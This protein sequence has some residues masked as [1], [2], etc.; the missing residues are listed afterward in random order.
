MI[1]IN[2]GSTRTAFDDATADPSVA[3]YFYVVK[4]I[5]AV[6]TG[7]Q[8]NEIDL[9]VGPTPVFDPQNTRVRS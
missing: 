4:A 7:A 6:G 1:I 9:V 3:H 5:N 8:S 2:T